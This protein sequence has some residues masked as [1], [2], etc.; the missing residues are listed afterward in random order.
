MN[1]FMSAS[2]QISLFCR[3]NINTKKEL[4]IRSSEMGL[5]IYLVK[6]DNEK[7]PHAMAKFFKVTKAMVTNMIT[8][9]YKKGYISK[10]KDEKDKRSIHIVPTQKAIELVEKTYHEYYK[11]LSIMYEIMGKEDFENLIRLIEKANNILLEGKE[12]G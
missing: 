8:S 2:E 5:L 6:T 9:L 11:N 3:L 1:H 10:E 7:T 12:N 4:P